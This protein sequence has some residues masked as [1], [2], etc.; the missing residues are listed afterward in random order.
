M[1]FVLTVGVRFSCTSRPRSQYVFTGCNPL[2]TRGRVTSLDL[3]A[4]GH[5]LSYRQI[6]T[7]T[8]GE[9]SGVVRDIILGLASSMC[10]QAECSSAWVCDGVLH[11]LW[12][13]LEIHWNC[14][15]LRWSLCAVSSRLWVFH[16]GVSELSLLL[17]SLCGS[18]DRNAVLWHWI[19]DKQVNIMYT[20]KNKCSKRGFSQWCHWRT[21]IGCPKT[22][23]F[24]SVKNIFPWV[25]KVLCGPIDAGIYKS[26]NKCFISMQS[27]QNALIPVEKENKN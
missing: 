25:L 13:L 9:V 23:F 14:R 22:Q 15:R 20:R 24:L 8:S 10:G 27:S 2:T 11:M 7:H 6:N 12:P 19:S 4:C 21:I 17:G 18:A 1:Q 26:V 3:R 16:V 5:Q